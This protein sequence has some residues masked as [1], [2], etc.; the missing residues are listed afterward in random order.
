[1]PL[2]DVEAS[3]G[4][5]AIRSLEAAVVRVHRD[6]AGDLVSTRF[7][8]SAPGRERLVLAALAGQPHEILQLHRQRRREERD[9]DELA[10]P[11]LAC[12]NERSENTGRKQEAGGEVRHRNPTGPYRN[13]IAARRVRCQKARSRLCDEVICRRVHKRPGR[14]ERR[15][16]AD[17]DLRMSGVYRVPSEPEALGST[18]LEVV[19]HDVGGSEKALARRKTFVRLQVGD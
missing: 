4:E 5:E 15:D 12:P 9:V 1:M 10:F 19:Q 17:D 3:D 11:R 7:E 14:A 16:P 8:M 6:A 2:R 18:A 13:R